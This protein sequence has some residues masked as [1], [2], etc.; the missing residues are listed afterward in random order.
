MNIYKIFAYNNIG[1]IMSKLLDSIK[2]N[3]GY[4]KQEKDKLLNNYTKTTRFNSK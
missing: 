4:E 2:G 1:D 3:F